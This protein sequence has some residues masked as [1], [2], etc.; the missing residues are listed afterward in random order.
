MVKQL[1]V[2]LFQPFMKKN[3]AY[4]SHNVSLICFFNSL[5]G[6]FS[7]KPANCNGV[8]R[9]APERNDQARVKP[10]R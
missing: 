3:N 10:E 1:Q 7:A 5:D 4:R 8:A 9:Y 2:V 6:R